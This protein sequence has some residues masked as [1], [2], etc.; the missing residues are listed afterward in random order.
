MKYW[1]L[2]KFACFNKP[3]LTTPSSEKKICDGL[4]SLIAHSREI[5]EKG[6]YFIFFSFK[7]LE[8]YYTIMYIFVT[9]VK[10]I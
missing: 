1:Y 2:H 7:R 4:I 9:A 10:I 6:N 8:I 3:S 5:L